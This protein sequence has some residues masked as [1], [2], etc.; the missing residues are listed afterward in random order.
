MRS[1][2]GGYDQG[3]ERVFADRREAGELLAERLL[4]IRD[5][6]VLALPRG[7]VE[8]AE[9]VAR[10]L[11]GL[12][13]VLVSR[14]IGY[15]RQPEL[16]VGAL[17]EGGEPV[18]DLGLLSRLGL[19]PEALAGVVAVERRELAR[20]VRVYRGERPLPRLQGREVIV[21][22]DGLA[23]GATARAALRTVTA[24]GPARVTLAVPVGAR[25]TVEAMRLEAD[26][27]VVLCAP[28]DFRAVG[29]WYERFDQLTDADVLA[30][31][32]RN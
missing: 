10:R 24:A 8:V 26:E 15:P 32:S 4:G 17:A 25:D 3:M 20:R 2:A 14:K 28:V 22:D 30:V 16:G 7:G 23:T 6:V 5:P 11:G 31:L 29:Q 19:T 18:F 13:D 27:V 9:P 1:A 21:V 12:L